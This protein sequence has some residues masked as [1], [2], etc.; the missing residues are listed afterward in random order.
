METQMVAGGHRRDADGG[1]GD[2]DN[3][4]IIPERDSQA[5]VEK[6]LYLADRPELRKE[7]GLSNIKKFKEYFTDDAFAERWITLIRDVI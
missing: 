6:V 4:Y 1:R 2:S 5:I 7:M 3:G